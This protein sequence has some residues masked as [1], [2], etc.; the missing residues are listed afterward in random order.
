V[1]LPHFSIATKL[2]AI[3]AL[4]A[5]VTVGLAV[6]AVVNARHH[7][8]LTN[9][10]EGALAGSQNVD[11]ANGLIY[12]VMMEA[13]A[14]YLARDAKAAEVYAESMLSINDRIG[15]VVADWQTRMRADDSVQF[16]EFSVRASRFQQ[17]AT[18]LAHIATGIGPQAAR[19]WG[20][21]DANST[22]QK[23][24]NR[25]LEQL[26]EVYAHRAARVYGQI[27]SQID[28]TAWLMTMLTIAAVTLAGCGMFILWHSVTRP[29]TTI[30]H[31][32]EAVAGGG[33]EM[34]IPYV[35]RSD[36]VGGLARSIAIF[37]DA[38]RRN[39]E[40][41]QLVI[42]DA[43]ARTERQERLSAEI[44]RFSGDVETTVSELARISDKMLGASTRLSNA[45]D[46]A[47]ERTSGAATA[48]ADASANVRDI[49]SAADEL[50]ASVSEIDRQVAQ[51]NEIAAKAVSET[52]R[53]NA[54]VAELNEAAS[55]IGDVVRLITDIA[56][57]RPRRSAR[58]SPPCSSPP[59]DRARRSGRSGAPSATSARSRAPSQPPSRSRARPLRKSRAASK[60]RRAIP[61]RPRTR[62][63]G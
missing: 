13:R 34:V 2:Y 58:R 31:V 43:S 16:T 54:A 1:K 30:T 25:D 40:L 59:R 15:A 8:A 22:M 23:E 11:R 5:T 28:D 18:E 49:A 6:V 39:A 44:V 12:G 10:F 20:D 24:L 38:M 46:N 37:Q 36:E 45:A 35:E 26:A 21:T 57:R 56:P 52:E 51:S 32:T 62:S 4:L 33:A 55:R 48:S 9:E 60:P 50:A 7:A 53:T 47:A 41:S 3:F 61:A 19:E 14:I 17:F 42:E 27:D 63:D 29:L